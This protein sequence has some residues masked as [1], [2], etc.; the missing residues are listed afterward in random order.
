MQC[1]APHLKYN[2]MNKT[3]T[4]YVYITRQLSILAAAY[5]GSN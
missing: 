3:D 1:N 4:V 5:Y 2:G